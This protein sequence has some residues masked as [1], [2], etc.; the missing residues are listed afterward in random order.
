MRVV[1]RPIVRRGAGRVDGLVAASNAGAAR[2][3]SK[4][5]TVAAARPASR[6]MVGQKKAR[7]ALT[8]ADMLTPYMHLARGPSVQP[9]HVD[10]GRGIYGPFTFSPPAPPGSG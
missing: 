8:T 1:S 5:P 7:D 2:D 6:R 4:M 10:A 3:R 9:L